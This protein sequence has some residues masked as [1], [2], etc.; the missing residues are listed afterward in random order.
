MAIKKKSAPKSKLQIED[1][2][3]PKPKHKPRKVNPKA[4]II[5]PVI[6]GKKKPAGK[7]NVPH[8]ESSRTK[9]KPKTNPKSGIIDPVIVG[10]KKRTGTNPSTKSAKAKSE[11][12]KKGWETRRK[13]EKKATRKSK[14]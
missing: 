6:V 13:N 4:G 11:A 12:A 1:G 14:K 9:K 5:D 7:R 3:R 2:D 10:R 8:T